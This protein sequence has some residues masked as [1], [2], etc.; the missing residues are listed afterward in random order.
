[1]A[2]RPLGKTQSALLAT[3]RGLNQ[4]FWHED[5]GWHWDGKHRTAQLL[6][7]LVR[8]GVM[9]KTEEDIGGRRFRNVYRLKEES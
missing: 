9:T 3:M 2:T 8:R 4:T 5:C 6:D 7:S 1:M